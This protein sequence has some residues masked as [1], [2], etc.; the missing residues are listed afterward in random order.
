VGS[1]CEDHPAGIQLPPAPP[2]LILSP[3][4]APVYGPAERLT[5]ARSVTFGPP[6]RPDLGVTLAPGAGT[7]ATTAMPSGAITKKNLDGTIR[8]DAMRT[9]VDYSWPVPGTTAT[10][11][12]A[13]SSL[14]LDNALGGSYNHHQH[15]SS[16]QAGTSLPAQ[17]G[18]FLP[19]AGTSL[20]PRAGT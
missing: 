2:P 20:P 3:A 18:T 13:E 10:P 16:P 19:Q 12:G 5:L 14:L 11:Q 6:Q 9:T 4:W 8:H 1:P 7:M 15:G 17:A